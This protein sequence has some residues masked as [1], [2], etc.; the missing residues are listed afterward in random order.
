M[1]IVKQSQVDKLKNNKKLLSRILKYYKDFSNTDFSNLNFSS[2]D[3]RGLDFSNTDFYNA[4]FSNT[5]FSN[6]DFTY[7][8]F[9]NII[10][11]KT[12]FSKANFKN[13][14]FLGSY[15][16]N[17]NFSRADFSNANLSYLYGSETDFRNSN[18]S[19]S[20][21]KNSNFNHST[22]CSTKF[23]GANFS[24]SNF[25][26]ANLKETKLIYSDIFK[27]K[28]FNAKFGNSIRLF[29]YI[30]YEA[31]TK[32]LLNHLGFKVHK[33]YFIAYFN[34]SNEEFI[35][36]KNWSIKDKKIVRYYPF[37]KDNLKDFGEGL[38]VN[39]K[40]KALE[41]S[42]KGIWEVKIYFDNDIV[43]PYFSKGKIRVSGFEIVKTIKNKGV[44][45]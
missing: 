25:V 10:L 40:K 16:K 17:S 26:K 20:N 32:L 2:M 44:N 13:S 34:F 3:F 38:V 9:Q 33:S 5:D 37:D 18:F 28:F 39:T 30:K 4:D 35:T 22:F 23:E 12:K 15:F 21:F 11:V 1:N 41:L 7:S 31:D 19:Y 27:Q 43:V 36:P 14:I 45:K 42:R 6:A 8:N 24:F 29:F